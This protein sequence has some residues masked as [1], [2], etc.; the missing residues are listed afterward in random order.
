MWVYLWVWTTVDDYSAM[1]WPCQDGFH[2]PLQS[3]RLSIHNAWVSLWARTTS[4]WSNIRTYLKLPF[5]WFRANSS[6]SVDS[7][8]SAWA[9]YF[10]ST[11]GNR[12][13]YL[14]LESNIVYLMAQD[15]D[16]SWH[17]IRPIKDIPVIPDSSWTT[18]KAWTWWAGIFW[19]SSLWLISISSDWTTRYTIADKNVGATTVYNNWNSLSE[20]NCGKYYQRWNN[21]WFPF[22]WSVTTSSTQVDVSNYW[23]WNYYS[24]STFITWARWDNPRNND[25]R[26][27]VTGIQPKT[28][29]PELKNAYI[30]EYRVPWENTLLYMPMT[31]DFNDHS[32]NHY[33]IT[34]PW[35]TIATVWSIKC[36]SFNNNILTTNVPAQNKYNMT[37][38]VWIRINTYGTG[39]IIWWNPASQY[40]WEFLCYWW[41]GSVYTD[42]AWGWIVN[43]S[44]YNMI[45]TPISSWHT[46]EWHY[47]CY[48]N[49]KLYLD[50]V[51]KNT[52]SYSWDTYTAWNSYTIWG[53]EASNCV[54][55][56]MSELIVENGEWDATKIVAYYN[57]TKTNYWL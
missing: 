2:V 17:T 54:N 4:W 34:N 13:E 44:Y 18:L 3:E 50:G 20:A 46:W 23:P 5:A 26:W 36:W 33:T 37:Y 22:T 30:G 14:Y 11:S 21:Y 31:E 52:L 28:I 1:Q 40:K 29:Y 56:Y 35:A 12:V 10:C 15:Y 27:W 45:A 55:G 19:S 42:I 53:R 39:W 32:Q 51:L 24:S 6:W 9:Y 25:L 49:K 16:C 7:Q 47:V 41:N 48:S 57:L 8:N 38:S 43:S